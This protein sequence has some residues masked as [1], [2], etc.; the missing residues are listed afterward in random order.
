MKMR[1]QSQIAAR[2]NAIGQSALGSY[3]REDSTGGSLVVDD[4]CD[5]F[6]VS[7]D[8]RMLDAAPE[9]VFSRSSTTGGIIG[10][11]KCTTEALKAFI[12]NKSAR[13]VAHQTPTAVSPASVL[14]MVRNAFGL[15][16][17]D[18]AEVFQITRQ[19]AYQWMKLSAMEQV[20]SHADRERIKVLYR[21][22]QFW[23]E[24]PML[25]GRWLRA[26]LPTGIT[27]LDILKANTI[28]LD[29]LK[30]AYA[31]LSGSSVQRRQ[32][33]GE[34]AAKAATSLANA[35]AGLGSGRQERKA[36]R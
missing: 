17:S 22:A 11:M 27:V 18:T 24:Q 9:K 7:L 28:D 13:A 31:T 21:A 2:N 26:I 1:N 34:R 30:A 5:Y 29:T 16:V 10:Y 12:S 8:W 25:K 14:D 35:F 23:N 3:F 20:R 4:G 19:T 32:D 15:N 36:T 6:I 33:E